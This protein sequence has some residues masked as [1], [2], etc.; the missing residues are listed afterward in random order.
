MPSSSSTRPPGSHVISTVSMHL[1]EYLAQLLGIQFPSECRHT[2]PLSPFQP[3]QLCSVTTADGSF[4]AATCSS[5]AN[6]RLRKVAVVHDQRCCF[7]WIATEKSYGFYITHR[8]HSYGSIVTSPFGWVGGG[9]GG[10][11]GGV[12][13]YIQCHIYKPVVDVLYTF[14]ALPGPLR[15]LLSLPD[16]PSNFSGYFGNSV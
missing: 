15:I 7:L 8:S 2:K 11:G 6:S 12:Q 10:G 4:L 9:G 13:V 3:L 14:V 1:L 5:V 16:S